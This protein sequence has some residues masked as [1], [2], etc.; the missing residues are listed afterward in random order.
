MKLAAAM[1]RLGTETAFEVLVRAKALEAQGRSIIHLEI[2]QPD[3]P[4]FENV[5]QAGIDAIRLGHTRYTPPAGMP[6]LR[7]AIAEDSGERRGLRV[8]PDEV[9]VSPGGKPNLF[10]PTLALSTP[11]ALWELVHEH[12]RERASFSPTELSALAV[13]VARAIAERRLDDSRDPVAPVCR[14]FLRESRTLFGDAFLGLVDRYRDFFGGLFDLRS[15]RALG[16]LGAPLERVLPPEA[17]RLV[18]YT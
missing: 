12:R 14:H 5:A 2:G 17:V 10:F 6:S 4:T 13:D 11:K 16:A 1:S 9:V 15:R 3:Y 8:H 18:R 7:E